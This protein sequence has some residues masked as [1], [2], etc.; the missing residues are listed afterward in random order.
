MEERYENI[1]D[2]GIDLHLKLIKLY[3][4]VTPKQQL[5]LAE[6][7]KLVIESINKRECNET[8]YSF[9][10]TPLNEKCI[11]YMCLNN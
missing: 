6:I 9:S 1:S 4:E 8:F 11:Q 3:Y 7:L 2:D 5:K 10:N